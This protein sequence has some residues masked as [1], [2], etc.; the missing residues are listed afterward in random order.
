MCLRCKHRSN[1][2]DPLLD[3]SLDIKNVNSL[4]EAFEQFVAP[5]KLDMDNAYRCEKYDFFFHFTSH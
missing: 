5:D 2:Y 1:T 4:Q 3:I